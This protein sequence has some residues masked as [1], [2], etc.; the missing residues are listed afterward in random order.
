MLGKKKYKLKTRFLVRLDYLTI[1]D[2]LLKNMRNKFKTHETL[3][4]NWFF[5]NKKII[6]SSDQ[7]ILLASWFFNE[8]IFAYIS[9]KCVFCNV[10]R[11]VRFL[12]QTHKMQLLAVKQLSIFQYC[13]ILYLLF[14]YWHSYNK[15]FVNALI[16]WFSDFFRII[17]Y[18]FF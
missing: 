14:W 5:C 15:Q 8:N 3:K 13:I 6:H 11:F 7:E 16:L 4:K 10:V 17:I 12:M 18:L 2:N 1:S 9:R